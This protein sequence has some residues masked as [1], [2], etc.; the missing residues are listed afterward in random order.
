MEIVDVEK[1][2]VLSR[3]GLF[4]ELGGGDPFPRNRLNWVEKGMLLLVGMI[5]G[6]VALLFYGGFSSVTQFSLLLVMAGAVMALRPEYVYLKDVFGVR[7]NTIFKFYF[8]T[9]V[10]WGV[11]AAGNREKRFSIIAII[12]FWS[13]SPTAMIVIRSV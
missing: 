7:I 13:K 12:S 3:C 5:G 1:I 10:L 4:K 2:T 8:Q 9:W 11:A 6:T